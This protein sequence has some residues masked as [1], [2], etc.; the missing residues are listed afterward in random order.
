MTP[1][2]LQSN[3]QLRFQIVKMLI[4][5]WHIVVLQCL[6][7]EGSNGDMLGEV[8]LSPLTWEAAAADSECIEALR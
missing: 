1:F 8:N 7:G 6:G 4:F 2:L 5:N 3:K